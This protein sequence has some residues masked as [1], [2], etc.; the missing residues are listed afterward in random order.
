MQQRLEKWRKEQQRK[1]Q[2][3]KDQERKD[4]ERK[5]QQRL[6]KWRK[7]QQRKEQERRELTRQFFEGAHKEMLKSIQDG[8]FPWTVK[9]NPDDPITPLMHQHNEEVLKRTK[10]LVRLLTVSLC[11]RPSPTRMWKRSQ[12]YP[13]MKKMKPS[14]QLMKLKMTAEPCKRQNCWQAPKLLSPK[15]RFGTLLAL[16]HCRE[17][18]TVQ[19]E[20]QCAVRHDW[21]SWLE[22]ATRSS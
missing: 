4:Q 16:L 22:W 8:T 12:S 18:N 15:N 5:V 10:R 2:E 13:L 6:E 1:E 21:P 11:L 9:F 3:R 20:N 19:Q 14:L 17:L 7:E